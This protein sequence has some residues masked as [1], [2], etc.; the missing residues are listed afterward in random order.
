MKKIWFFNTGLICIPEVL[1]DLKYTVQE[2]R[3][4]A[5]GGREFFIQ[6]FDVFK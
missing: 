6:L 2:N 4:S 3:G 5:V 1:F